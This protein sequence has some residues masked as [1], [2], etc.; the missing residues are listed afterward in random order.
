M[1]E[2]EEKEKD[3]NVCRDFCCGLKVRLESVLQNICALM[4]STAL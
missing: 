1:S 2:S 3:G 4:S